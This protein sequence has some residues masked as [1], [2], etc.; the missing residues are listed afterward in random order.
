MAKEPMN[1][2]VNNARRKPSFGVPWLALLLGIG[3]LVFAGVGVDAVTDRPASPVRIM[4]QGEHPLNISQQSVDAVV[5]EPILAWRPLTILVTERLLSYDELQG[6]VDPGA[7]V[8]LS[9]AIV[10]DASNSAREKRFDGAGLYPALAERSLNTE[11]RFEIH[12]AY[13]DNVGLG[14]G[15]AAVAA[16]AQ[17]AAQ[18]LDDGRIRTPEFWVAGTAL[19]LLLTA[20]AFGFSLPRRRRRE[21]IYRRLAAAQRQLAVVVLELEALEATYQ[22]TPPSDRTPA[23]TSTWT[24]IRASS[25]SLARSEM[26]LVDAVYSPATSLKPRTVEL[27]AAFEAK[28]LRLAVSADALMGAGSVLGGLEGSERT[29]DRLTAP[30]AFAARELL[31]RIHQAPAGSVSP[32][33]IQRLE[34]A[35]ASLLGAGSGDQTSAAAVRSWKKAERELERAAGSVDNSLRRDTRARVRA[36]PRDG[37]EM[38]A[39]RIGLGLPANGSWRILQ[40]LDDAN[41]AA[42]ALFGPM[43][44]DT[45]SQEPQLPRRRFAPG[46]RRVGPR[47]AR[48]IACLGIALLSL[49]AGGLVSEAATARPTWNLTGT[50]ALKSLALDGESRGV[51][52]AGIRASLTD[53]FPADID[54]TVAVRDAEEYLLVESP[55][56]ADRPSAGPDLDP[57]VLIDALWRVKGEF[58]EAADPSTGEVLPGKAIIPV[59]VFDDG[60]ATSPMPITGAVSHGDFSRLGDTTWTYGSP[61]VATFNNTYV[62]TQIE[63]LSRGLQGNGHTDPDIN[64]TLLFWLLAATFALALITAGQVLGFVGTLSTRLGSFGSNAAK[65]RAIRHDLRALALGLDESRL[66]TLAVLGTGSAATSAEADQR[67]FDRALAV[68]WRMD[69]ELETTVLTRRHGAAY[70]ARIQKLADLVAQLGIRD[71]DAARRTREL[72]GAA[73]NATRPGPS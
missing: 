16:A 72:L 64:E 9:T 58:P 24:Q 56:G 25:L 35:L 45:R 4:V 36:R 29:F 6:R 65:L 46:I 40:T 5:T 51:S 69:Q 1:P 63:Q 41:A 10:D 34:E 60:A 13:V 32:T 27:V 67:I 50:T 42:K 7:D 55:R 37:D 14:H 57:V 28:A 21:A 23:F 31:A 48:I 70:A 38:S 15:P 73:L 59:W 33:R 8:I 62:S 26:A 30:L 66:N 43:P 54:L 12:H 52:E 44:S 71:A 47:A 49:A 20:L 17:R 18:V 2:T 53:K 68:A 39:L 3:T 22:A 11:T 19:G 61:Y